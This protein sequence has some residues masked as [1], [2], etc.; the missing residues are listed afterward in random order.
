QNQKGFSLIELSIVLAIVGLLAGGIMSGVHLIRAAELRSITT[1][2]QKYVDAVAI[3]RDKYLDLPGDMSDATSHWGEAGTASFSGD[4]PGTNAQ[5]S[6]DKG[7]CNGDGDG[8]LERT[9][10]NP[11]STNG[12]VSGSIWPM[13]D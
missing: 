10:V 3:F 4:C 13:P 8:I 11:N 7:T 6:T 2:Y 1:E 12:I 9:P 5:P